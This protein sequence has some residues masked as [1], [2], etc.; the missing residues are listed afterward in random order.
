MFASCCP[1]IV[2]QALLA[3]PTEV[4]FAATGDDRAAG[5]ASQPFATLTLAR[6]PKEEPRD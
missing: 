6:E 1:K 3:A 4:H 2:Q 5:T